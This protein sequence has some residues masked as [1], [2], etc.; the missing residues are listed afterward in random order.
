MIRAKDFPCFLGSAKYTY[1]P[2]QPLWTPSRSYNFTVHLGILKQARISSADAHLFCE[3]TFWLNLQSH[4][5]LVIIQ[6][7][8]YRAAE[9]KKPAC[10]PPFP[11][12]FHHFPSSSL[13]FLSSWTHVSFNW[14]TAKPP[15][16]CT[17]LYPPADLMNQ[18]LGGI[19][20]KQYTVY[21]TL[22]TMAFL[23]PLSYLL[24]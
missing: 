16:K 8:V 24:A 3:M 12:L 15:L 9:N 5:D 22:S 19:A 13:L 11:L 17:S 4:R 1:T 23:S 21:V 2:A 14:H 7:T 18:R 6:C 20:R 10:C